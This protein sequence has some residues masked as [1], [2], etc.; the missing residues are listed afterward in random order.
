MPSNVP[1]DLVSAMGGKRQ[2]WKSLRTADHGEARRRLPPEL[3]QWAATFDAMRRQRSL[4][5]DDIATAVWDHYGAGLEAGDLERARRP[6]QLEIETATNEAIA[7]AVAKGDLGT[8]AYGGINAMADVEALIGAQTWAARRRH[9]RLVRLR[10]DLGAGDTRLIE[11]DADPFLARHNLKI[12][13]RGDRYREL[14]QSLMRAEIE[15]LQ[16]HAERDRGDYTGSPSDPIIVEPPARQDIHGQSETIMSIFAKYERENPNN[17]RPESFTQA[18]RDVQHFA[19]FVGPRV[20][21]GT[22]EKRHV[23][24]WKDLLADFPV[25]VRWRSSSAECPPPRSS[26]PTERSSS[27]RLP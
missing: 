25:G 15:Q 22:I 3:D 1:T 10:A 11:V 19:D 21:P 6:T 2:I 26:P 13:R 4:T 24:E 27:P 16:R 8:Y 17:I 20:K 14:C 7:Q 18:R 5:L 12:D 23:R 9:A